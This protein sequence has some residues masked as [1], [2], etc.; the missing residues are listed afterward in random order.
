MLTISPLAMPLT[1]DSS[2]PPPDLEGSK[3]GWGKLF[4]EKSSLNTLRQ[5]MNATAEHHMSE[6]HNCPVA[7]NATLISGSL[8]IKAKPREDHIDEPTFFLQDKDIR[9]EDD[10]LERFHSRYLPDACYNQHFVN[11]FRQALT[12]LSQGTHAAMRYD[13]SAGT[14]SVLSLEPAPSPIQCTLT[15]L[16]TFDPLGH[17][18][19]SSF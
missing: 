9:A 4:W 7:T 5:L 16:S 3:F 8:H 1:A 19:R 13:H 17:T 15:I 12:F 10:V 2:L 18:I 14:W 6:G 11:Q